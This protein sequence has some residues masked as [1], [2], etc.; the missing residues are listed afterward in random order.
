MSNIRLITPK[1]IVITTDQVVIYTFFHKDPLKY[2]E[3]LH[4]T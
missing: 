1:I 3:K 2:L 4:C